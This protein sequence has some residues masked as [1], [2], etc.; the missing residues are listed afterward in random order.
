MRAKSTA[1][2][3]LKQISDFDFFFALCFAHRLFERTDILSKELQ[4]PKTSTV[5]GIFLTKHLKNEFMNWRKDDEFEKFWT[6][7]THMAEKNGADPPKLPKKRRRPKRYEDGS[8]GFQHK[9]P[10]EFYRHQYFLVLDLLCGYMEKRIE[11][12]A[13]RVLCAIED[14]LAAGWNSQPLDKKQLDFVCDHYKFD[15]DKSRLTYQLN[16]LKNLRDS[17]ENQPSTLS[18]A[19]IV[20]DQIGKSQLK[21]MVP[22]VCRLIKLYLVNSASTATCER[23]FS[24]LRRLKTFLRS[25]MNQSRLNSLCVLHVLK[26]ETDNLNIKSLINDFVCANNLAHLKNSDYFIF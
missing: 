6:R 11:E 17:V 4:N 21:E 9:L 3:F 2:A 12:K 8:E 7:A 14:L 22:Q 26:K 16:S 24:V 15:L 20:I 23:F 25:T 1:N 5:E 18:N 13:L 10:K 19:H